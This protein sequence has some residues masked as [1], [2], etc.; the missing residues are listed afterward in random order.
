MLKRIPQTEGRGKKMSFKEGKYDVNIIDNKQFYQV[1]NVWKLEANDFK[2][3]KARK[4]NE[5]QLK[6]SLTDDEVNISCEKNIY[7][8]LLKMRQTACTQTE[9]KYNLTFIE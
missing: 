7:S 9:E 8:R 1:R 6:R 2:N 4:T 3:R 5:T